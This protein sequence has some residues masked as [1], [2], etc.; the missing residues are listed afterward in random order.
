MSQTPEDAASDFADAIAVREL[1]ALRDTLT[2]KLREACLAGFAHAQAD[3]PEPEREGINP[4][5]LDALLK[6]VNS[7]PDSEIES[8][9]DTYTDVRDAM[10]QG[11]IDPSNRVDMLD[12]LRELVDKDEIVDNDLIDYI[13]DA[14]AVHI[15]DDLRRVLSTGFNLC[16]IDTLADLAVELEWQVS[17]PARER[18]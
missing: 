10:R 16:G 11:W 18:R 8:R 4:N 13:G 2:A 9:A 12:S 14:S 5:D 1:R 17:L 15:P 3:G 7:F 6:E